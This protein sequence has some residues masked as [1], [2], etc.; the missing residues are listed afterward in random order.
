[1][2]NALRKQC[3]LICGVKATHLLPLRSHFSLIQCQTS[4]F[5]S[6]TTELQYLQLLLLEVLT[7]VQVIA[8]TQNEFTTRQHTKPKQ[9]KNYFTISKYCYS[10]GKKQLQRKNKSAHQGNHATENTVEKHKLL[11][12]PSI[13]NKDTQGCITVF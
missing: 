10:Q 13:S 7:W 9:R 5:I 11:K 8:Q 3:E 1:M 2:L 6:L 4:N 12:Y